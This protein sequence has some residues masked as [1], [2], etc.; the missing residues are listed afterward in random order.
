MMA[1]RIVWPAASALAAALCIGA[2]LCAKD[3]SAPRAT[4][5]QASYKA[6]PVDKR[7]I[8]DAWPQ[9]QRT[10][11]WTLSPDEQAGYWRLTDDQRA[12]VF[13]L[14]P[15]KRAAAWRFILAQARGGAAVPAPDVLDGEDE[16]ALGG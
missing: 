7:A 14:T 1:I 4:A 2:P 11:Y 8:Y 12:L 15:E 6:W 10:Y 13:G 5:Q 3:D 16:T 9:A